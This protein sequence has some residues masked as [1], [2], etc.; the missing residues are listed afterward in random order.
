MKFLLKKFWVKENQIARVELVLTF[1]RELL[2]SQY[3]YSVVIACDFDDGAANES[4]FSVVEMLK[5]RSGFSHNFLV[6]PITKMVKTYLNSNEHYGKRWHALKVRISVDEVREN[7]DVHQLPSTVIR[8]LFH[9]NNEER[10]RP[11]LVLF[12]SDIETSLHHVDHRS[13]SR[14]RRTSLLPVSNTGANCALRQWEVNLNGLLAR[15]VVQPEKASINYCAGKC[16]FP[17]FDGHWNATTNAVIRN[18]FVATGGSNAA[19]EIVVPDAVCIPRSLRPLSVIYV[20]NN[21]HI[22]KL[23]DHVVATS[24]MCA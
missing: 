24:C 11:I 23:L 5:E 20:E 2:S 8:R 10:S 7:G 4:R 9:L 15:Y 17:A 18:A 22:I 13:K 12:S 14:L 1:R 16:P 3:N 6:V 19:N 21:D